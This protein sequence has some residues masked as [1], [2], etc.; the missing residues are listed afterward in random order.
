VRLIIRDQP[1][2]Q[3]KT[4]GE[5]AGDGREEED[6]LTI[7]NCWEEIGAKNRLGHV[8]LRIAQVSALLLLGS[9][10]VRVVMHN[11]H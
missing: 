6:D 7:R 11:T 4:E 8:V 3:T 2:Q 10:C 5:G 1:A 9:A